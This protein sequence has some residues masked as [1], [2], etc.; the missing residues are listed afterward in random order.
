[1]IYSINN[2]P[3]GHWLPV[4]EMRIIRN[5]IDTIRDIRKYMNAVEYHAPRSLCT[6]VINWTFL[7]AAIRSTATSQHLTINIFQS[8]LKQ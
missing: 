3:C 4:R 6:L 1:M 7:K 5:C 8:Y 2:V